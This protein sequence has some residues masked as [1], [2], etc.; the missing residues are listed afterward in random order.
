ML[1]VRQSI[2]DFIMRRDFGVPS[3]AKDVFISAGFQRA[4]MVVV[5]LL[6]RGEGETQ[7]GVL[8]PMPCPHTL[9]ALLDD[10]GVKLVP[11]QLIEDRG[12][13]VDLDEL[14]RALKTARGH[15]KPRAIYI[16]NPGNPTGHVQDWKS[17]EEV[18]RFAAAERLLLLVDEVYQDSVYGQG[19]ECIS[20]KRVLFE[21]DKE[22][23]E[24]VEL[25]SF[26]SLSSAM[27]GECALRAGYMELVNIDPEVMHFVD[28]MLCTDI[29]A[30]VTGQLALD[31]MVNPPKP[32]DL[33]YEI[34]TQ[35]ILLTLATLSQNA[36][37]AQEFLNGLP[38]MS[39]QP[40]MG[41]I[42]LYPRLR[43]PSEII[44]KAKILEVEADVLYCQMLLEEKGV[45]LGAGCQYGETTGNH[46]LR[47]CILV[48][49]DTL[50][51]VLAGLG[52]F[53]LHG[54]T[55]SP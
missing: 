35:E 25:F 47:L 19:K 4:L 32:G 38:G 30:P 37:R 34:Y 53:H 33:S 29:S 44:E 18:I 13:A 50:E 45:L 23:S 46:H 20:Y 28:T 36:Q 15:C 11:Y 27:M 52:S 2:A 22:Y 5:K 31:L 6:A 39:C 41:G 3:Y 55:S 43:L 40:A 8:T 26:H 7:T 16:S 24:T 49:P 42:Y 14:R 51:K 54:H 12:W 10:A 21:M 9:P 48:L 1:H 17:I